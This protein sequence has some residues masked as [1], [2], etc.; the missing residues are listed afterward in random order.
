MTSHSGTLRS[1]DHYL[2]GHL[3][4]SCH[5]S[6]GVTAGCRFV[7]SICALLRVKSHIC[8]NREKDAS[9]SSDPLRTSGPRLSPLSLCN[10]SAVP[11]SNALPSSPPPSVNF[12]YVQSTNLNCPSLK[13]SEFR[14]RFGCR[15]RQGRAPERYIHISVYLSCWW[16]NARA[17]TCVER[18]DE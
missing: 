3:P 10:S 6:C 8:E 15:A 1:K 11:F 13:K 5:A 12:E 7:F 18:C 2:F 14:P 17:E 4:R 9:A 16:V